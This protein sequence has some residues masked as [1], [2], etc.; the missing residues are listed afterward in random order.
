MKYDYIFSGLGLAA[1]MVL[2]EMQLS[3]LFHGKRILILEPSNKNMND[4]TWCFWEQGVGEWEWAVSKEWTEADFVNNEFQKQ[5]LS[6]GMKYKMIESKIFYETI[7]SD[8]LKQDEIVWKKEKVESFSETNDG[9]EVV[10]TEARYQGA[11]LFNS[12]FDL[13]TLKGNKRHPLLLQHFKGWFVKTKVPFFKRETATF[14]DFSVPQL[15]NTRFMYVLPFSDTEALVEYTLF[16]SEV[17][18]E[19]EYFSAI[20]DY[21]AAKGILEYEIL[22]TE[23]GVIP[24]TSFPFWKN[25]SRKILN[26]GTA[27]GWTKASTGYTFKKSSELAKK[28]IVALKNGNSNLQMFYQPNRFSF[29]DSLFVAVL[30]RRNELG[31]SLFSGMFSKV[32]PKLVFDFLDEKTTLFQDLKVINACP[33]LPFLRAFVNYVFKKW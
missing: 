1:L 15:G 20:E 9:V 12:I 3:D 7:I 19:N 26:I 13:N 23:S 24:M 6:G 33:K 2:R 5:C 11:I 17:L 31:Y 32:K 14:M 28:L 22:R 10:T 8:L 25:N 18:N 16:S 27:G 30:F 21:L 4:R 29:Y